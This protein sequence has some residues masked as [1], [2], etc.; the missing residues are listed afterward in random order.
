MKLYE[1]IVKIDQLYVLLRHFQ[2]GRT[3]HIEKDCHFIKEKL[4]GGLTTT[5]SIL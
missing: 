2:F 1:L 3:K 4:I 5:A